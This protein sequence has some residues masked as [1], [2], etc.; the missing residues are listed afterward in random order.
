MLG[1][2]VESLVVHGMSCQVV[3]SNRSYSDP[4]RRYPRRESWR[5]AHVRRIAVTGFGRRPKVG[6]LV[7]YG[8][9]LV[10]AALRLV[11]A[12]RPDVIIGLST[13]PMLEA[14][15]VAVRRLR[16]IRSDTLNARGVRSS[17]YSHGR[18]GSAS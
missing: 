12:D 5:G 16:E 1:D 6:R 9:F 18:G 10:G 7:D 13:P 8:T 3:A 15:A 11:T 4:A 14:L 2:L 17:V